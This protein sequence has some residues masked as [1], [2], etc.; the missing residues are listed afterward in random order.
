MSFTVQFHLILY[1]QDIEGRRTD[2]NHTRIGKQM[3]RVTYSIYVKQERLYKCQGDYLTPLHCGRSASV[4]RQSMWDL[5]WKV[6]LGQIFSLGCLRR[7]LREGDHLEDPG[8]G[9][10]ILKMDLRELG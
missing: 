6:V 3:Q 7:D 9:M 1:L 2:I 10:I 4:S 5:S 8:A